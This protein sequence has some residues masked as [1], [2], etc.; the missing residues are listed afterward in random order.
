MSRRLQRR[1]HL[2]ARLRQSRAGA[3]IIEFAIV[4]P[5]LIVMLLGFFDTAH[6]LY[7]KAQLNGLLQKA[8]RDSTLQ[9]MSTAA[10]EATLDA[11]IT[12]QVKALAKNATV[13]PTRRFYRNYND[14]AAK[15]PESWNDT[16]G[17]KV[18]DNN[19]SYTD[20]NG[21]G[22]WDADGG[23]GGSTSSTPG[24]GAQDRT[25]Y[26]VKVSYPHLFP[27]WKFIGTSNT[28]SLSATAVLA[29]QPYSDQ[30]SYSATPQTLHCT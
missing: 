1:P 9:D 29:N 21:N 4:A 27:I 28:V 17:D 19:E 22:V 15:V 12:R 16:N 5:V 11:N 13:T 8:A 2:L 25:I 6:T 23:D 26:T 3:T 10:G 20:T 18:C 7:M 30:S 24:G 14:A